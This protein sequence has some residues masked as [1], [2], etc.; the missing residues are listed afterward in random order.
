LSFFGRWRSGDLAAILVLILNLLM[1]FLLGRAILR[2][3][4]GG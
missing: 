4:G 3:L 2:L 1:V